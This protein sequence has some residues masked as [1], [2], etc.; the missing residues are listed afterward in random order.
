M[1]EPVASAVR[2]GMLTVLDIDSEYKGNHVWLCQCDCGNTVK[3]LESNLRIGRVSNC[4]CQKDRGRKRSDISGHRFGRLVAQQYV[5]DDKNGKPCWSF[6]CD[7]GNEK[8]LPT[9]SV[10]SGRT[11]SCGCIRSEK[12]RKIHLTDIS[13]QR[14]GRLIAVKSTEERD[15]T[16]SVVWECSCDCG[17]TIWCSVAALKKGS[18]KSCGC[19]YK[20]SRSSCDT[21]RKDKMD[22]TNLSQLVATKST[23]SDNSSGITGVC[24]LEKNAKWEAYISFQKKRYYLGLFEKKEDAIKARKKAEQ[25]LHDPMIEKHWAEMPKTRQD[26]YLAYLKGIP[27]EYPPSV[28]IA[29]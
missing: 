9:T 18:V 22:D 1:N 15:A 24:Y 14:F 8:I 5:F 26:E 20:E 7:C 19:Y 17:N 4:G 23:R 25:E 13:G 11:Q 16:G 10:Q 3:V 27:V 21:Y 12:T 29:N 2:F 28:N 6:L